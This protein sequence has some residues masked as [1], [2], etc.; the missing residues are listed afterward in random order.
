MLCY[1]YYFD[2]NVVFEVFKVGV[3]DCWEEIVVKNWVICYV[4]CNFSCG[5]IIKDEYINILVQDIQ[6]L[7]FNIQCL[8]FVD[9]WVWQ[10]II[11][12]FD[13]EWMNKVLF[14]SVYQCVNSYFQ[15]IEY[16]V[17]SL[18]DVVELVLLMLMKNELFLE[19]FSQV[20]QLLVFCGDG[21]D[22]VNLF[23]VDVLF[24]VVGW[25]VKNQCWV[26][27]VIGK[28]LCFELL[29]LVGGNDCWVLLFQYNLQ[30]LGIVMDICQVDNLQYS[31]CCC[32]WDYDMMLSLWC[33]MFWLG[34]DL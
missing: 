4:G 19:F 20:Y 32:S 18:F 6:W 11:L 2:D 29:L 1:D 31:N 17:C 7:V 21:F 5:Y 24:N 34:I 8:I 26:N 30:C 12:V 10:V 22:C 15:N 16:V 14:Y 3:V 13:F 28:L 33:V 25:M 9:C 23:K 27:V